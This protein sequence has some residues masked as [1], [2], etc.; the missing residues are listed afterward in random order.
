[1][2]KNRSLCIVLCSKGYPEKF[3]NNLEIMN[4]NQISLESNEF[5]FHAGTKLDKNKIFSNGGRVLNFTD[6]GR[7]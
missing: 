2:S 6:L 3:T 1:M 5:I 7:I 4:L